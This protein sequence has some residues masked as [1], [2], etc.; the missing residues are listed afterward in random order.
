MNMESPTAKAWRLQ[1]RR[2]RELAHRAEETVVEGEERLRKHRKRNQQGSRGVARILEKV[3][4]SRELHAKNLDWKPHLLINVTFGLV[5]NQN[6]S[7][8][9][10]LERNGACLSS[11]PALR[12]KATFTTDIT[13]RVWKYNALPCL[14]GGKGGGKYSALHCLSGKKVG[15]GNDFHVRRSWVLSA[16]QWLQANNIYYR[17]VTINSDVLSNHLPSLKL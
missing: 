15:G 1:H 4:Q 11:F 13:V 12:T 2:E 3:G 9:V 6:A 17:N 10:C 8:M 14:S 5:T 7:S 16:L